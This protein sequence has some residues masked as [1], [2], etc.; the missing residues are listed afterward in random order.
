[1][2][3]VSLF[4]LF[5]E[6]TVYVY[7]AKTVASGV[8]ADPAANA[9]YKNKRLGMFYMLYEPDL[10][11]CHAFFWWR[12]SQEHLDG[13]ARKYFLINGQAEILKLCMAWFWMPTDSLCFPV[14]N[15]N[16]SIKLNK[17]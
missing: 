2:F 7:R 1:M 17:I 12:K 11:A 10:D 5:I 4:Q 14:M 6:A 3:R 15:T 16:C 8:I 13:N 9:D